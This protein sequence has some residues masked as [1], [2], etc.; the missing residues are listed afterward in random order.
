MAAQQEEQRL[1]EVQTT[2]SLEIG[3]STSTL[4]PGILEYEPVLVVAIAHFDGPDSNGFHGPIVAD[5]H[6][7]ISQFEMPFFGSKMSREKF[8]S[9]GTFGH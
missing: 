2:T 6:P 8:M 9:T 4:E 7:K 1:S 3:F 5:S